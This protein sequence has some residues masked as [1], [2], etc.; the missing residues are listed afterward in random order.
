MPGWV[1]AKLC[2]QVAASLVCHAGL[3]LARGVLERKTLHR[4]EHTGSQPTKHE[5]VGVQAL[6]V[7]NLQRLFVHRFRQLP[8]LL[9]P[10]IKLGFRLPVVFEYQFATHRCLTRFSFAVVDVLNWSQYARH[11]LFVNHCR[12]HPLLAAVS[13][14]V[15]R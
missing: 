4:R 12:Q 3:S 1:F 9:C 15:V 14:S 8:L 7:F 13:V 2:F 6:V 10:V 11:R 5:M